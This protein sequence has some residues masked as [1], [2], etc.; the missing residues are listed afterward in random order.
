MQTEVAKCKQSVF[1][2][3]SAQNKLHTD[4]WEQLDIA[5]FECFQT[6]SLHIYAGC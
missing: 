2:V 6:E 5:G 4:P 3:S 1:S